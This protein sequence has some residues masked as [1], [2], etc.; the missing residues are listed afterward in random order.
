M[1]ARSPVE[2]ALDSIKRR[3]ADCIEN[4]ENETLGMYTRAHYHSMATGIMIAYRIMVDTLGESENL[5]AEDDTQRDVESVLKFIDSLVDQISRSLDSPA[6]MIAE[7]Q[8]T[9]AGLVMYQRMKALKAAAST[10][11]RECLPGD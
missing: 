10:L 7:G 8:Y 1:S 9:G 2:I 3:E 6:Y 5:L 11:R 4:S